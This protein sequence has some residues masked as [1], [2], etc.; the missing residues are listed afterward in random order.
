[1]RTARALNGAEF[2]I[3]RASETAA[4]THVATSRDESL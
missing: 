4:S 1:M 3:F 2:D